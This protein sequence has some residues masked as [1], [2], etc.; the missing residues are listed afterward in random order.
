MVKLCADSLNDTSDYLMMEKSRVYKY[1]LLLY[2]DPGVDPTTQVRDSCHF[3][4][5]LGKNRHSEA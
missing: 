4:P 5:F 1:C 2:A 3:P